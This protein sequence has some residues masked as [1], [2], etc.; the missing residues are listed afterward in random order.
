MKIESIKVLIRGTLQDAL[1]DLL[2]GDE[3][4][5][6]LFNTLLGYYV[7][8]LLFDFTEVK[9]YGGWFFMNKERLSE[10]TRLDVE[11]ISE[12]IRKLEELSLVKVRDSYYDGCLLIRIDN[13]MMK[14]AS[15]IYEV[16]SS[17]NA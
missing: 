5:L 10:D 3:R 13:D 12:E 8:K 1:T 4:T 11:E 6:S 7:E 16:R 17:N 2:D 14:A 15:K 9:H